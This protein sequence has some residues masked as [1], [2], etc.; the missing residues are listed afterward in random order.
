MGSEASFIQ[1]VGRDL[2]MQRWYFYKI[3]DGAYGGKRPFD[4]FAIMPVD[5]GRAVC[6]EFKVGR[7]LHACLSNIALHQYQSLKT[8]SKT[9][10]F[11][12]FCFGIRGERVWLDVREIERVDEQFVVREEM[13]AQKNKDTLWWKQ[14]IERKK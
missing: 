5:G 8:V 13:S 2:R 6:I 3:P 1:R 10:G 7:T 12:V 9:G 11:G 14:H 4:V